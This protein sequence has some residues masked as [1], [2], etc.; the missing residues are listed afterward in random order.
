LARLLIT[1]INIYIACIILDIVLSYVMMVPRS[2]FVFSAKRFLD[3]IVD[4]ALEPIRRLLRPYM[5]DVPIDIS[6]IVLIFALN[7]LS[8]LVYRFFPSPPVMIP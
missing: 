8:S 5:R 7:A 3:R 4:P 6:P 2:G 1:L